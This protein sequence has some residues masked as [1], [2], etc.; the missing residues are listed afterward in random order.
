MQG[1]LISL[2]R[3]NQG[4]CSRTYRNSQRS[5]TVPNTMEEAKAAK[6]VKSDNEDFLLVAVMNHKTSMMYGSAKL[7]TSENVAR[8]FTAFRDLVRPT[9]G[10]LNDHHPYFISTTGQK[11]T[12]FT[13]QHQMPSK[14]NRGNL[15]FRTNCR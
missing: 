11:V 1:S 15:H 6:Q 3:Q 14:R 4:L 5:G 13:P 8:C 7:L 2:Q 9:W 10:Y 12:H